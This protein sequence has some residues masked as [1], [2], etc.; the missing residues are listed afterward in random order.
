MN[1]PEQ[2]NN[3]IRLQKYL[4]GLGV[5]SRRAVEKLIS[6]GN[7]EVNGTTVS[8]PYFPIDPNN[9]RVEIH[10]VQ[11]KQLTDH[12]YIILNKPKG[13]VTSCKDERGRKTVLDIVKVKRRIFPV[14]RLDKDTTGLLL[15]TDDGELTNKLIHPR[16]GVEKTYKATV[17]G[18]LDAEKILKLE[19]GVF[20][21][22][23]RTTAAR[24]RFV[25]RSRNRNGII[26]TIHEG[27]N[28]QVRRMFECIGCRVLE[29]ERIKYSFLTLKGLPVGCARYLT[30]DEI[31][32]LKELHE[33]PTTP[34]RKI[35]KAGFRRR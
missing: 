20:L 34:D 2:I 22:G 35:Y 25:Y 29:L 19:K 3:K 32:R 16:Y 7:V 6:E 30:K 10:G 27:R 21:D 17:E 15:L 11:K 18:Y 24:I 9:D 14:G 8:K 4:A 28:K 26:I 23:R 12:V 1:L 5:G 33:N 13:Y 31:E